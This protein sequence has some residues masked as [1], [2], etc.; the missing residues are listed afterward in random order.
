M[1][2]LLVAIIAFVIFIFSLYKYLVISRFP[3]EATV[4]EVIDGDTIRITG[5]YF[6][7]Y[8]GINA[9]EV[10]RK[11]EEK[12]VYDPQPFAEEAKALNQKLVEG[13][14]VRLKYDVVKKDK[15][16]RLLAYI[17]VEDI[18]VNAQMISQGYALTYIFPRNVKHA[19]LLVR[20][21]KEAKENDRGFWPEVK[22]HPI[23]PDKA[24]EYIGRIKVLEGKVRN[25]YKGKKVI[26]LNFGSGYKP[27]FCITIFTN[28]VNRFESQ[29]ISPA[30]Y[31]KEKKV[32]VWGLIKEFE[33]HPEMVIDDPS[34]I[35]VLE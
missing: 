15:Y 25:I 4:E 3:K 5:G 27:D 10:G 26:R 35:E 17:Y 22:S 2:Y 18:L 7:R 8:I 23:P 32:R 14:R 24:V 12:W 21:Q 31:Y 19:N 30:S 6:V 34:Q 11:Q 1:K 9:P 28:M 29:G 13:K 20:L 16:G 33:G